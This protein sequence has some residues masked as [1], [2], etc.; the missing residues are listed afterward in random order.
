MFNTFKSLLW[1]GAAV[2]FCLGAI[3]IAFDFGRQND[4][5]LQIV[6]PLVQ[7]QK[8]SVAFLDQA[9]SSTEKSIIYSGSQV[10]YGLRGWSEEGA[11]VSVEGTILSP[12]RY[13]G[14]PGGS[15]DDDLSHALSILDLRADY[16]SAASFDGQGRLTTISF[17]KL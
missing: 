9:A 15:F 10:L 12:V 2:T 4:E 11:E 8:R 6:L 14:L 13:G 1:L 16:R 17:Y 5:T 3:M 7:I